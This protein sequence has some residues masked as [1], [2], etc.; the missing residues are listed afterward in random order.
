MNR[1]TTPYNI[2][3]RKGSNVIS[4]IFSIHVKP[5]QGL[6]TNFGMHTMTNRLLYSFFISLSA[7]H[8]SAQQSTDNWKDS[9][10]HSVKLSEAIT[11]K[12]IFEYNRLRYTII[13]LSYSDI[14]NSCLEM[15]KNGKEEYNDLFIS[16]DSSGG[17]KDTIRVS[18]TSNELDYLVSELLRKGQARVFGISQKKYID[19]VSYRFE[20]FGSDAWRFYYLSDKRPF[21]GV[22][23]FSGIIEENSDMMKT[24]GKNPGEYKKLADRLRAIWKKN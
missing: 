21:F 2:R 10:W 1:N 5:F 8:L 22:M 6:T 16:L 12:N 9:S 17:G 3:P 15:K 4:G 14:R 24:L 19:S 7:F 11:D 13:Y 18:E 23:E 20:R